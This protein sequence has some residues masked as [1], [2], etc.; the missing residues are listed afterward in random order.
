[1]NLKTPKQI[2]TEHPEIAKEWNVGIIGM[3]FYPLKLIK[4]TK[5]G[6]KTVVDSDALLQ[7]W[8]NRFT[9]NRRY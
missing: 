8:N 1:M 5:I 4:G 3:L 2:I 7:L 6:N 9:E